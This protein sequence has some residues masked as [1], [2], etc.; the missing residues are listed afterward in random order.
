MTTLPQRIVFI[1][2]TITI[3][4]IVLDQF[5]LWLQRRGWIRWRKPAPPPTGGGGMA[6]LLTGFQELVE[7]Q[8]RHVIQDREER[9]L[10]GLVVSVDG[11]DKKQSDPDA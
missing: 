1:I 9:R 8:V 7:P 4:L 6:G 3:A 10:G 2:A 5:A 11:R